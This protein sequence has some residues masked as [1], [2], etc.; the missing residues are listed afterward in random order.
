MEFNVPVQ[1]VEIIQHLSYA[2]FLCDT[3]KYHP[4]Q[5]LQSIHL[6]SGSSVS[7]GEFHLVE[8]DERSTLR[9]RHSSRQPGR[10]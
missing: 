6:F 9:R 10:F 5:F 7:W 8:A 2:V 3:V 1:V 4:Q